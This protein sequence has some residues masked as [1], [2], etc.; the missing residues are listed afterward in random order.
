VNRPAPKHDVTSPRARQV[1]ERWTL[2][3]P[4]GWISLPTVAERANPAIH[5]VVDAAMRGKPRDE[6]VSVRIELERALSEQVAQARQQ[7]VDSVHALVQPIAGVPVSASLLVA[8]LTVLDQDQVMAAVQGMFG[9]IDGVVETGPFEVAGFPALRRVRRNL[10]SLDA[11]AQE[12]PVW[13]TN[14]D[15]VVETGPDELLVLIFATS[16]DPLAPQLVKMFDAMA[17]TLAPRSD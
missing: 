10:R 14:V 3:L 15:Y 2:L 11:A 4:P 5:G 6:L 13:H 7:G 17:Q 1:G 12:E 8:E 16:H 9:D